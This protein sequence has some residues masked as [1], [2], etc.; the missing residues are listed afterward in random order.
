MKGLLLYNPENE[1]GSAKIGLSSVIQ[2]TAAQALEDLSNNPISPPTVT[3]SGVREIIILSQT[4]V[5]KK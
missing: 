4:S 3:M 1:A 2:K 5:S